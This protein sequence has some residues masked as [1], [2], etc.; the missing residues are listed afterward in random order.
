MFKHFPFIHNHGDFV[1]LDALRDWLRGVVS[2]DTFL[3][4]K[5]DNAI[6]KD[7]H[8][9]D[10]LTSVD[11]IDTNDDT[12]KSEVLCRYLTCG[13]YN[14]NNSDYNKVDK[15]NIRKDS[16]GE[17]WIDVREKETQNQK[18]GVIRSNVPVAF[19]ATDDFAT[20]NNKTAHIGFHKL[21]VKIYSDDT[22]KKINEYSFAKPAA[23]N[24]DDDNYDSAPKA[25]Y[26]GFNQN[27]VKI[28]DT[29][30]KEVVQRY[31]Y[32]DNFTVESIFATDVSPF[33]SCFNQQTL[34]TVNIALNK[35]AI[36]TK[37]NDTIIDGQFTYTLATPVS[38]PA[39]QSLTLNFLIRASAFGGLGDRK[40]SKNFFAKTV[41]VLSHDGQ[42]TNGVITSLSRD[43]IHP[44]G[45]GNISVVLFNAS[46]LEKT[47]DTFLFT[48]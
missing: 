33:G 15:I 6:V 31:Q 27:G 1:H 35:Q 9:T 5:N 23:Y 10:E 20:S 8:F 40:Y 47:F 14:D 29:N 4:Y 48:F 37:V 42:A 21:G 16:H 13:V 44:I 41:D 25:Y 43:K 45:H 46:D 30:T 18:R 3:K 22:L 12:E 19:E 38:V 39:G 24:V 34:S 32:K 7:M 17:T 28:F 26:F 11:Y 2:L 36:L